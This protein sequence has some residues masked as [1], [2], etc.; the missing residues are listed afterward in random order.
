ML[1]QILEDHLDGRSATWL[2]VKAN[3]SPSTV[4][5]ILR[6]HTATV[7]TLRKLA[8]GLKLTRVETSR[9]IM[10]DPGPSSKHRGEA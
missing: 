2:A 8:K 6:G 3:V 9:L 1:G 10:A 7:P 4:A 5:R